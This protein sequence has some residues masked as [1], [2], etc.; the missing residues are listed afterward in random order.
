MGR[1]G[2]DFRGVVVYLCCRLARW[3]GLARLLRF[4]RKD[5]VFEIFCQEFTEYLGSR[6]AS[7]AGTGARKGRNRVIST[8]F[9]P[10]IQYFQNGIGTFRLFDRIHRLC[11]IGHAAICLIKGDLAGIA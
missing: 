2:R 3:F 1:G 5:G 11:Y 7:R 10:V 9:N 8:T 4:A 6:D